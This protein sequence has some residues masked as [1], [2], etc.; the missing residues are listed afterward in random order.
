MS[1]PSRIEGDFYVNGNLSSKTQT[2][3][4]GSVTNASI[5]ASAGIAASKVIHQFQVGGQLVAPGTVVDD[6]NQLLHVVYG[7]T[8]TI[9]RAEAFITTVASSS[10]ST[11]NVDLHKSTGGGA[12]ATICSGTVTFTSTYS[13][14]V[15]YALT[16]SNA[17]LVDGDILQAVITTP[18][19]SAALPQGLFLSVL[20]YEDPA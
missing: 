16:L 15:P 11:I 2:Y 5:V 4:A 10:G 18:N 3:P 14:R 9:V 12:F 19:S 8:A 20:L 13:V 1:V 6:M 17:S 7:A